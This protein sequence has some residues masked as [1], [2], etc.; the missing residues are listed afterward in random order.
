MVVEG[1]V[2]TRSTIV[3]EAPVPTRAVEWAKVVS[4]RVSSLNLSF[5]A[6]TA[7]AW[8]SEYYDLSI[9]VMQA[10]KS[11]GALRSPWGHCCCA[12]KGFPFTTCREETL[13]LGAA[14]FK[15]V[16]GLCA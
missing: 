6:A 12:A 15:L 11:T 10:G 4:S 8:G 5:L 14:S 16:S 3:V 9:H 13:D 7:S 2:S 1:L